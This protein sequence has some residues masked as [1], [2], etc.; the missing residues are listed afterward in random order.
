MGVSYR[1]FDGLGNHVYDLSDR[2]V[3]Y[4]LELLGIVLIAITLAGMLAIAV[5]RK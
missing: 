3:I 1:L 5:T 2:E 4:M